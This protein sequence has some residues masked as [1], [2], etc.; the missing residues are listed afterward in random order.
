MLSKYSKYLQNMATRVSEKGEYKMELPFPRPSGESIV[1]CI[2][3]EGDDYIISDG[4]FMDT[5]LFDCGIDLW[6]LD[7]DKMKKYFEICRKRY[8]IVQKYAPSIALSANEK[9]LFRRIYDMSTVLTILSH[10][11]VLLY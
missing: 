4:G 3:E 9:S 2:T 5:H 11:K 8:G 10:F 1:L 6:K 7:V